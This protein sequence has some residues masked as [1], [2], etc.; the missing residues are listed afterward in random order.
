MKLSA[1]LLNCTLKKSPDVSNTQ[2]L[3]DLVIGHLEDLDTECEVVPPVDYRIPFGVVPDMGEGDERTPTRTGSA[4]PARA[5]PSSRRTAPSTT[6]RRRRPAGW[7]TTS[8]TW[9]AS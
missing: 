5:R 7:P 6:T 4:T 2:A 9:R 3:M 8:S 1:V